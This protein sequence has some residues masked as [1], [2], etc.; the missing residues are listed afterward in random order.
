MQNDRLASIMQWVGINGEE[1]RKR[2]LSRES[3]AFARYQQARF[4]Q[5]PEYK[6][7]IGM[8]GRFGSMLFQH[9]RKGKPELPRRK[10]QACLKLCGCS[11]EELREAMES[12]FY[13]RKNGEVMTWDNHGKH[14]QHW[15]VDHIK[16][17]CLFDWWT[18][19]GRQEAFHHSNTQPLWYEDHRMKCDE[20]RTLARLRAQNDP[21]YGQRVAKWRL[22]HNQLPTYEE[23]EDVMLRL[24]AELGV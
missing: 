13:T 14:A 11:W 1:L 19:K 4:G 22:P 3:A 21:A 8:R 7:L 23:G 18:H 12:K 2:S 16:P 6:K 5:D 24:A 10:T 17:I 20:D 15:V 9:H